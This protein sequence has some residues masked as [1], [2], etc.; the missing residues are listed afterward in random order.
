VTAQHSM[1]TDEH[2]SPPEFV[3]LARETMGGI[4][5]DP[6]SSPEWNRNVGATRII[7]KQQNGLR[8]P[9]F[10]DAPPP[11]R[12]R[13][14]MARPHVPAVCGGVEVKR[15]PRRV[16]LNP[17]GDPR[18]ALV[19]AFWFAIT[20]YFH[21]GWMTAGVWIGFNVE[22]LSRLQRVGARS[23]PLEHVTLVPAKRHNYVDGETGKLQEDA[24]HASFVTLLTRN[25]REVE[26]FAAIGGQYG[27]IVNGDRR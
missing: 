24:P 20:E 8:T 2:G 3:E 19:A 14:S 22:Q 6:A 11:I 25:P 9:W 21:L 16:I 15:A 13:T 5:V 17:P 7:T 27:C 26:T 23:H 4:D 1:E 10:P 12:L 18:G